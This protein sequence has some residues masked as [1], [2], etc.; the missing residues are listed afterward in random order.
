MNSNS[1]N[2]LSA[3]SAT[4]NLFH[5]QMLN[6]SSVVSSHLDEDMGRS[7][8]Y[9]LANIAVPDK[10]SPCCFNFMTSPWVGTVITTTVFNAT[11]C[12]E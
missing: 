2:A 9:D 3:E 1:A 6:S 4:T 7:S 11:L 8:M 10:V 12:M 5:N